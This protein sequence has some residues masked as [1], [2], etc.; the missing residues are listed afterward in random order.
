MRIIAPLDFWTHGPEK[1]PWRSYFAPRFKAEN[2]REEY[3]CLSKLNSGEVEE[4]E[5]LAYGLKSAAIRARFADAVWELGGSLG[6]PRRDFYRY[7]QL[8]AELYLEAADSDVRPQHSFS[9]FE[10]VTRSISLG[11]QLR[12][13]ALVNRGF[14]RIIDF[15]AAAE[16]RHL[17]LWMTP[18]AKL[19]GLRG[20]SDSQRNEILGHHEKR[21]S[22]SVAD[23]DLHQIRMAGDMLAKHFHDHENY[24]RAK[25]ITFICGEA[26][27]DISAG[28]S[29][30]LAT[31]H[32]EGVMQSYRQMG[33]REEAERVQVLLEQRGEAAI[34]EMKTRSIEFPID[35]KRIEHAIAERVNVSD[36][37]VALYRL[38]EWCLPSPQDFKKMLDEGGFVAHRIMPTAIIGGHGLPVGIVGTD[39]DDIQ[40]QVFIQMANQMNFNAMVFLSGIEEWK[41]K[42]ELGGLPETPAILNSP[43]IPNSRLSLYREGLAAFDNQDYVKCIHVLLPQIENSLRELLRI[44]GGPSTKTVDDGVFELKN[45]NDVLHESRVREALDEKLWAFLN[46]LYVDKR[47]MNLRNLVAHGVASAEAFNPA[48]ASLVVQSVTLLSMIRPEAMFLPDDVAAAR[49]RNSRLHDL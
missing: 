36:P 46:V 6:S 43:L 13:P 8:A 19:M 38:A 3:P 10:I 14:R 28:M 27:L 49:D 41:K 30:T 4:W 20:L 48:T 39:E 34:A 22:A 44:L 40:G 45:M 11:L 42:F 21:L 26:L 24:T 7:A 1:N 17:G 23:R 15:A 12:R 9:F 18:L 32:I 47:G 25:E 5:R 35:R 31:H 29:A 37:F 33:L 2:G 16:Q